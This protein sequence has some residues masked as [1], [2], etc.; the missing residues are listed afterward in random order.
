MKNFLIRFISI[1]SL[2]YLFSCANAHKTSLL[3]LGM[4]KKEVIRILGNPGSVAATDKA[5]FLRYF[6]YE[7]S[8]NAWRSI[9]AT[10]YIKL[11]N[12]KVVLYGRQG[13]FGITEKPKQTIDLNVNS[14]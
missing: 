9:H 1:I 12:D 6:L 14:K 10:Y 5:E 3:S 8:D 2:F 11:E 13:D 7:T 4:T